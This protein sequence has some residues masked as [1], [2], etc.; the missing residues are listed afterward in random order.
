MLA[1][2][3]YAIEYGEQM[4]SINDDGQ[5]ALFMED[6]KKPDLVQVPIFKEAEKLYFEK[7]VL[8][9]YL[10]NHPHRSIFKCS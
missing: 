10:S 6:I 5:T 9:F 1:T 7:Q 4:K 3:D 8:G 2:L